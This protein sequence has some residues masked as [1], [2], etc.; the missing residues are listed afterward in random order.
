MGARPRGSLNDLSGADTCFHGAA[1]R[2]RGAAG[3]DPG[4][5]VEP[6]DYGRALAADAVKVR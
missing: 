6:A 5:T 1:E 4:T 3:A 2:S